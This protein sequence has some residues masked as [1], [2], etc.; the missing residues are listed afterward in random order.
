MTSEQCSELVGSHADDVQDAPQDTLGNIPSR[1]NRHRDRSAIRMLHHVVAAGDSRETEPGV[2]QR[3]DYLCA[4]YGRDSARH[5]PGSYQKS[6]YVA[7]QSQL[8]GWLD[9]IKQ[10]VERIT[11]VRDC[12]VFRRPFA[13]RADA[14][15]EDAGGA[16]DAVLVLLD[17]VRHVNDSV[18][19]PIMPLS[20]RTLPAYHC[21]VQIE[22]GDV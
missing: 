13:D 5:K 22:C 3:L 11:Q 17:D 1:M 14:W 4:R 6:G 21:N 8:A 10:G 18:H 12:L 19:S 20:A 16:P 7:C 9:Y 15:A 2:L